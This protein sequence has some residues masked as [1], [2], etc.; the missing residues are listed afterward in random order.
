MP[1]I[2]SADKHLELLG[3]FIAGPSDTQ[4]APM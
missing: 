3:E 2:D 1:K 4:H